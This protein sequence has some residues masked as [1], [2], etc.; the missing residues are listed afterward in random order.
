MLAEHTLALLG[1][2]ALT[3]GLEQHVTNCLMTTWIHCIPGAGVV[4]VACR[5]GEHVSA[6]LDWAE[7]TGRAMELVLATPS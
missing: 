5:G 2:P 3:W 4:Y 7:Q 6:M 1:G